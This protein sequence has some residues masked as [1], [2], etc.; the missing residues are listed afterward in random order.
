MIFGWGM[1]VF[2]FYGLTIMDHKNN[3]FLDMG[4]LFIP[5][6]MAIVGIFI[7]CKIPVYN[8]WK[9]NRGGQITPVRRRTYQNDY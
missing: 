3:L 4:W 8:I 9:G 5:P 1:L 7:I 2:W 6:L